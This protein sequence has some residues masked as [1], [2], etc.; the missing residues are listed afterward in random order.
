MKKGKDNAWQMKWQ[1]NSSSGDIQTYKDLRLTQTSRIP[2]LPE[3]TMKREVLGWLIV[4]RSGHGHF[5]TYHKRFQHE[6]ETDTHCECREK[7]A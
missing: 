7:Q 4:A 6:E 5:A 2:S 3:L 1:T